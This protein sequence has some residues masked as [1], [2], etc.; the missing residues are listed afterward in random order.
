MRLC[1]LVW[2]RRGHSQNTTPGADS[3]NRPPY[4]CGAQGQGHRARGQRR[5]KQA[6]RRAGQRYAAAEATGQGAKQGPSRKSG[7]K[8]TFCCVKLNASNNGQVARSFLPPQGRG[9]LQG[10]G[11]FLCRGAT[12][13]D[14][15][16]YYRHPPPSA[17]RGRRDGF[18]DEIE[19]FFSISLRRPENSSRRRSST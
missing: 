3:R 11:G 7:L 1:G 14:G 18:S 10:F 9:S 17:G 13:G 16:R 4:F 6:H 2:G 8:R 12:L 5:G 15:R 19:N